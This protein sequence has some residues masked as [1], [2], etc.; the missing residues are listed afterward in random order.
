[1]VKTAICTND[2]KKKKIAVTRAQCIGDDTDL[3]LIIFFYKQTKFNLFMLSLLAKL[4]KI[5]NGKEKNHSNECRPRCHHL[6]HFLE[7]N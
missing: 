7:I 6:T 3:E 1:M 4:I 5:S 2:K